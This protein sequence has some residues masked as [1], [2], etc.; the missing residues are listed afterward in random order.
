MDREAW[1]SIMHPTLCNTAC[2]APL[3]GPLCE[4]LSVVISI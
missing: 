1:R 4:V 2:M 3:N